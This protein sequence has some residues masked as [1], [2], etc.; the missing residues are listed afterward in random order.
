MEKPICAWQC[1]TDPHKKPVVKKQK[2]IPK[3]PVTEPE[4]KNTNEK[5]V[6]QVPANTPGQSQIQ[7]SNETHP[8]RT[9]QIDSRSE[10]AAL[11]RPVIERV[12]NVTEIAPSQDQAEE[13]D[14]WEENVIEV[15]DNS[16][17]EERTVVPESPP[18]LK[19]THNKE[20]P[21][22]MQNDIRIIQQAWADMTEQEQPFTEICS[23]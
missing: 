6:V 1:I 21:L 20:L 17:T 4:N 11:Q 7:V 3:L 8:Q 2:Y 22:V 12:E 13:S 5:Q 15:E 14:D 10:R 18:Y 9:Y 23:M 19:D 16:A